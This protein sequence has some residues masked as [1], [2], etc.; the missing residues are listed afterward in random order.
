MA[1]NVALVT[2]RDEAGLPVNVGVGISD[3]GLLALTSPGANLHPG[4]V[5][6]LRGRLRQMVIEVF[7][8]GIASELTDKLSDLV[9]D[10]FERLGARE[11]YLEP[12][13]ALEYQKHVRTVNTT[14]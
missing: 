9:V 4:S 7:G 2:G 12:D 1:K 6:I 11:I 3:N 14:V 13:A 10:H 5:N 8:P